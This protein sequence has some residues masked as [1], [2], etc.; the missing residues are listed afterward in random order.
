MCD[1]QE[2]C[3]RLLFETSGVC[4]PLRDPEIATD[5]RMEITL[6]VSPTEARFALEA[7]RELVPSPNTSATTIQISDSE[8]FNLFSSSRKCLLCGVMTMASTYETPAMRDWTDFRGGRVPNQQLFLLILFCTY[9][10]RHISLDMAHS[11]LRCFQDSYEHCVQQRNFI[12]VTR[13][14]DCYQVRVV[15]RHRCR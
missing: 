9:N 5:Q 2:P 1:K 3:C 15:V 8:A 6:V 12:L 14:G 10:I 13:H 11:F 7:I 4:K